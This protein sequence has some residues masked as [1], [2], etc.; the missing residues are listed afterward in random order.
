MARP[1][2]ANPRTLRGLF[3][4]TYRW[5]NNLNNRIDAITPGGIPEAPEDGEQYARQD[6]DWEIVNALQHVVDDITPELGGTLDALRNDMLNARRVTIVGQTAEYTVDPGATIAIEDDHS[7]SYQVVFG[8]YSGTGVP[9]AL[10]WAGNHTLETNAFPFGMGSILTAQGKIRNNPAVATNFASFFL[11][12]G[13]VNFE[14][15]TQSISMP[16]ASDLFLSPVFTAVNGGALAVANYNNV[17]AGVNL[18]SAA[19]SMGNRFGV[20]VLDAVG[21]G[22]LTSQAGVNVPPLI[23]GTNNTAVLTGTTTI[24]TGNYNFYQGD[25]KPN[26][27]GGGHLYRTRTSALTTLAITTA[28]STVTLSSTAAVTCTLPSATSC[29][30]FRVAIKKTGASGTISIKSVS[31]QTADG[32]DITSGALTLS[33]QWDIVEVESDGSNWIIWK[34]GAP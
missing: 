29:K 23:K 6:A 7:Y 28:D 17:V 30:G 32:V 11:V 16:S 3:H 20:L 2:V 1:P 21:A 12:I 15:D 19:V 5:L 31:S 10:R 8:P 24:P 18:N 22:T 34:T 9:S 4:Y 26:R 33:T 25:T 14:A 27:W 13:Q